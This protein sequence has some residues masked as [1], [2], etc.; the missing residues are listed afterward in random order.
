MHFPPSGIHC[1]QCRFLIHAPESGIVAN[2]REARLADYA[3]YGKKCGDCHAYKNPATDYNKAAD[4]GDGLQYSCKACIAL[5]Y[6]LGKMDNGRAI[7]IT[8]RASLRT[9]NDA[10]NLAA[11]RP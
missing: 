2:R 1:P 9:Q 5:R 3:K 4:N 7:W 6:N 11:G 10:A 8:T